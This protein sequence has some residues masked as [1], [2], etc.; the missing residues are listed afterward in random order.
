MTQQ[1]LQPQEVSKIGMSIYYITLKRFCVFKPT[2]IFTSW[3]IQNYLSINIAFNFW[4]TVIDVILS[5]H[6]KIGNKSKPQIFQS[7]INK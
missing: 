4:V 2:G 3:F 6:K 1:T 5:C 7:K